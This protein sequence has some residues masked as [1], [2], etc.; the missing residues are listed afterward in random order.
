M[1]RIQIAIAAVFGAL[2][3]VL[4]IHFGFVGGTT[5]EFVGEVREAKPDDAL[6]VVFLGNSHTSHNHVPGMIERLAAND[7]RH[8]PIWPR[9]HA[10]G[11]WRLEDHLDEG[12]AETKIREHRPDVVVI[13]GQ[14]LEPLASPDEYLTN[15]GRVAGLAR[16][17]GAEPVVFQTWVHAP[18][19]PV[20]R[21]ADSPDDVYGVDNVPEDVDEATRRLE[22]TTA[23]LEEDEDLRVAPVG[24]VWEQL[25][26]GEEGRGLYSEDRGHSNLK[27]AYV[28][29]LV[30]YRTIVGDSLPADPWRPDEIS[31]QVAERLVEFIERRAVP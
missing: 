13:Q 10:P 25:R 29:A 18:G 12:V 9:Q 31:S 11:G 2:A 8:P 23:R 17:H 19:H 16:E 3:G 24:R 30:V 21:L 22:E 15:V 27:G 20:Y 4:L 26:T 7:E 5:P 1:T 14:S 28:A 6:T